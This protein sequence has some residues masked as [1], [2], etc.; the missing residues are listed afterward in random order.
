MQPGLWTSFIMMIPGVRAAFILAEE[1]RLEAAHFQ[2]QILALQSR[3]DALSL[4]RHELNREK[5]NAY[6][7]VVNVFS[8]YAWGTKQF[9]EVGGMPAQF[10]P[11]GGAMESDTVNASTLVA[12][13]SA[14]AME[15]FF[16]EMDKVGSD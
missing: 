10:H 3:L 16:R 7:L 14:Q 11:Q 12:G 13:R 6:K 2:G 8:Q 1:K 4:E 15:D 9:E 5:D